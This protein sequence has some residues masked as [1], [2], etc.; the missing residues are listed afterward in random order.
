[1]I[2]VG[3]CWFYF[4]CCW[5]LLVLGFSY[6]GAFFSAFLLK[7]TK[8]PSV[9]RVG[10]TFFSFILRKCLIINI[11]TYLVGSLVGWTAKYTL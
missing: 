3:R 11:F 5:F 2:V 7:P 9:G 10:C 6:F 4:L 1:M 8:Y